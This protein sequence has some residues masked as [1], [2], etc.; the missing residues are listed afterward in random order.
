[1]PLQ[2]AYST[3][4][5]TFAS[6]AVRR[7]L[8]PS[9]FDIHD[10]YCLVYTN[11]FLAT[12]NARASFQSNFDDSHMMMSMPSSVVSPHGT[13]HLGAKGRNI[14]IQVDTATSKNDQSQDRKESIAVRSTSIR[15]ATSTERKG[16]FR[17]RKF[18][19]NIA[20]S[21]LMKRVRVRKYI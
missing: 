19:R 13:Q 10:T 1:M 11:S 5:S 3:L 18:K 21:M 16:L 15:S 6:A 14:T 9:I 2:I 12:L 17:P 7:L 4:H 8:Y 20:T